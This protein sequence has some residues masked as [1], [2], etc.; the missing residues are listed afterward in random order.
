MNQ[1]PF[2]PPIT[3]LVGLNESL[4][5]LLGIGLENLWKNS[6]RM[7]E[8][9]RAGVKALGLEIFP[10]DYS[11]VLT[12]ICVPDGIDGGALVKA[13]KNNGIITLR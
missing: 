8:A 1:N 7:A 5:I 10:K 6:A 11:N 2:T 4:N 3:L 12:A 13:L 9:M